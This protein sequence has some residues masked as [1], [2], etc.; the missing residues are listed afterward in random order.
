[1]PSAPIQVT[2]PQLGY[3]AGMA[4]PVGQTVS[5]AGRSW[6]VG[7]VQ[8]AGG[9]ARIVLVPLTAMPAPGPMPLPG[10]II[11]PV[12]PQPAPIAFGGGPVPLGALGLNVLPRVGTMITYQG[13][14]WQVTG[15]QGMTV[16]LAPPVRPN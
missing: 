10:P 8:M 4:P 2:G 6:R 15:A 3:A 11:R 7:A 16:Y 1:M 5:Y 13:K 14:Y 9:V 12:T